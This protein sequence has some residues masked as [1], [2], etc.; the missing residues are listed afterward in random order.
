MRMID[1]DSRKILFV[2]WDGPHVTYL[3]SL[4]LPI[5][6]KL[7]GYA[8]YTFYVIQF[9]WASQERIDGI[10]LL[11]E[12]MNIHYVHYKVYTKPVPLL[13]KVMTLVL[14]RQKLLRFIRAHNINTLMPRG[15]MPASI[16]LPIIKKLPGLNLVYDADG[17]Q[18]E[19]RVDFAGLRPN[20]FK[21]KRLKEVESSIIKKADIVLTRSLQAKIFLTKQYGDHAG[22][23]IFRV[24]NGRDEKVFCGVSSNDRKKIREELKIP[25]DALVLVYCG[26][27]APQYGLPEMAKLHSILVKQ[28]PK[29]YW[30]VLTSN[31]KEMVPYEGLPNVLVRTVDSQE[32]PKYLSA[33]D[34]GLA[35]RKATLSMQGVAPIKIGEYMLMGLPIIASA[36]I[37]DTEKLLSDLRFCCMVDDFSEQQIEVAAQWI[38]KYDEKFNADEIRKVGLQYFSLGAAADSYQQALRQLN[39]VGNGGLS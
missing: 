18:I 25:L 8:N 23:K 27:L 7:K 38:L 17:L 2:V 34:F 36:G 10:K 6:Y 30:L 33:S 29:T 19:E 9:S 39:F 13:G 21:F 5:F 16:V 26:T 3:E 12:R 31:I 22:R 15:L 20:T 11:C 35:L 4:F 24:L 37:G 1:H 28:R 32:V 14:A